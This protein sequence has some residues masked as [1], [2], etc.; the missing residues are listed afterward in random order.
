MIRKRSLY[1]FGLFAWA[2]LVFGATVAVF[3]GRAAPYLTPD[4]LPIGG[5]FGLFAFAGGLLIVGA[6]VIGLFK[7]RAWR[8]TGRRANLTPEGGGLFGHPTFTGTE[9]GRTVRARTIKRKTS[10]GGESGTSKTT[11]TV[12]EADLEEPATEGLVIST[13]GGDIDGID[14]LQI[15]LETESVGEF[16][17]VGTS[18]TLAGDTLSTRAKETLREPAFLDTVLVGNTSDVLLE[19]VPD[20]DGFLAGGVTNAIERK[21]EDSIAGD[22]GTVRA[23]T[24]GLILDDDELDRQL[25]AVA[26]VADGF[27]SATDR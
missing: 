6:S 24:K 9:N 23:R 3:S 14:D 20:G 22:A 13:A 11:Y 15:S 25:R 19:A 27:E 1:T 16:A 18:D 2:L 8:K 26:A 5:P 10:G 7:R 4:M 17:A 12:V 21:L